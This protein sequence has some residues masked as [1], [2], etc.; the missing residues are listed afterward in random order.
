MIVVCAGAKSIL[1]LPATL[2][3]LET[4]G[5]TVVGYKTD[6]LPGFFTKSTGLKLTARADSPEEIAAIYQA[7][8]ELN[9]PQATLVVQSPPDDVALPNDL[10]DDAVLRALDDARRMGIRGAATTPFLLSAVL[11]A[12]QGRSLAANL[13]LLEANAFLAGEISAQLFAIGR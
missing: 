12:T 10:V 6:E 9:R 5:V 7:G 3:R 2:E 4:L 1:D 8:R 11:E 13:G